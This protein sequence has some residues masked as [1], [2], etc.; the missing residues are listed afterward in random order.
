[1]AC[2]P[3]E[4]DVRRAKGDRF[5]EMVLVMASKGWLELE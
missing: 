1:M 2:L 4:E 5:R 3:S